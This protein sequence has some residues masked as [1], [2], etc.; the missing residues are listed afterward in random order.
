MCYCEYTSLI[1]LFDFILLNRQHCGEG[2]GRPPVT[3]I[4]KI[5]LRQEMNPQQIIVM[6]ILTINY[7]SS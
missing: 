1:L 4:Y 5:C 6:L 2:P 3:P 7:F